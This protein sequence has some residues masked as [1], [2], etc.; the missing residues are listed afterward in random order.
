M[1]KL[2]YIF[3]NGILTKPGVIDNWNVR[4]C[5]WVDQQ[6]KYRAERYEYASDAIFR[7]IGQEQR[8]KDLQTVVHRLSGGDIILVGHS[9]G[10]DLIERLVKRNV[11]YFKEIHLI[12]AASENDF[13]KNGYNDALRKNGVGQIFIYHSPLDE[14]LKQA[15]WSTRLFGWLG[16]GYGYLGLTGPKYISK[17]VQHKVISIERPFNHSEWFTESN[18]DDTMKLITHHK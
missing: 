1:S 3:C 5:T 13:R 17:E 18:F 16:L 8:V 6:T 2:T 9:N 15:K 12:A 4:A 7:R 10:C 11:H 14:A